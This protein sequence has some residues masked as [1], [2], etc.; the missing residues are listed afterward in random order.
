MLG[1]GAGIFAPEDKVTRYESVIMLV[2]I[3]GHTDI[4]K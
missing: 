2:R 1:K 3:L 4:F